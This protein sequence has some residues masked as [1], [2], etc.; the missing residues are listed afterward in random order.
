M[1]PSRT[2]RED[3]A[4]CTF[5]VTPSALDPRVDCGNTAAYVFT[6]TKEVGGQT[7]KQE[8]PRCRRHA[9]QA[10]VDLAQQQGYEVEEI[11]YA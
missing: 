3:A 2:T 9:S 7:F 8:H 5:N 6:G 1:R 4:F 11:E 10:V